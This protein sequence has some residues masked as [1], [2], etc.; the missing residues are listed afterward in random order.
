[1]EFMKLKLLTTFSGLVF[2]AGSARANIAYSDP[3]NQG[4]QA[5]GDNLALDFTV[6][7][8]ISLTAIGVFNASGSGMIGG[9][10]TVAIFNTSTNAEVAGIQVTFSGSTYSLC[11]GSLSFDVCQ[12]IATVL[13]GPGTYEVDAVGFGSFDPNGNLATGARVLFWTAAVS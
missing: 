6:N 10:I 11:P 13:L 2:A 12:S 8:A 5:F 3:A 9:P 7:S 4:T 1:M